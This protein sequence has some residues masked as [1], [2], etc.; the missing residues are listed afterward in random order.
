MVV[1]SVATSII[2]TAG[3]ILHSHPDKL[4]EVRALAQG[5]GRKRGCSRNCVS[6]VHRLVG[7]AGF[8]IIGWVLYWGYVVARTLGTLVSLFRLVCGVQGVSRENGLAS[9]LSELI[10]FKDPEKREEILEVESPKSFG[11]ES[12]KSIRSRIGVSSGTSSILSDA[13]STEDYVQRRMSI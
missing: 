8:Y 11:V 10:E 5:R 1:L 4:Q 3:S 2:A 6:R 13:G 12:P 7:G 9:G